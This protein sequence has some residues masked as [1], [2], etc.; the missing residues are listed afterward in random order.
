MVDD[1]T[2]PP[3]QPTS[4]TPLLLI[5]HQG[6]RTKE[7]VMLMAE[8]TRAG[9]I[10]K[11]ASVTGHQL[12][13]QEK[14]QKLLDTSKVTKDIAEILTPLERG[15]GTSFILIEGSPGIG[16]SFL[17]KEIAYRWANKELLQKF[18][19]VLL[20]CLRNPFLQQIQSIDDLLQMFS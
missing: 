16:K 8:L 18:E 4:F 3:E 11:I 14:G 6:H 5:H 13:T 12:D 19:L 9:D 10:G 15:K 17:L 1:D 2:W 20:V 7:Q